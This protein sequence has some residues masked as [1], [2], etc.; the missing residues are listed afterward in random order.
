VPDEVGDSKVELPACELAPVSHLVR[1]L[2]RTGSVRALDNAVR[3][4]TKS[5]LETC[6]YETLVS[7]T[8]DHMSRLPKKDLVLVQI[9]VSREQRKRLERHAR[10]LGLDMVDIVRDGML[11]RLDRLEEKE[12]F[13]D[14]AKRLKEQPRKPRGLGVQR[15]RAG[16]PAL[17]AAASPDKVERS[18]GMFTEFLDTAVDDADKD[19]RA[20]TIVEEIRA[21]TSSGKEADATCDALRR[22]MKARLDAR[23]NTDQEVELGPDINPSGDVE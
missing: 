12:L 5:I 17:R 10:R 7:S 18:F 8:L 19:K 22:F 1:Q 3:T 4:A 9:R 20:Q 16:A 15:H 2:G 11:E 23:S 21:R 13:A 6:L 14:E